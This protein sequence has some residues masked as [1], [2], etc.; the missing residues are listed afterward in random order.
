MGSWRSAKQG[1][2]TIGS[3]P[4]CQPDRQG[5][6]LLNIAIVQKN[7]DPEPIASTAFAVVHPFTNVSS[8]YIYRYLRSPSFVSYVESVQTGIAYPAINDKQ[9]F[10][11]LFP[12]PPTTEQHR[13]VAKVDELM[14]LCD[15]LEQQ[16]EASLG[17]HQ[18]LVETLLAALTSAASQEQLSSAWQHIAA[19]FETLF[20]TEESI[21][22][23]KQTILQLAVM[24]K[25][26]SQDPNDEPASEL[27]K[28]IAVEKEK[29][30]KE[31]KI[32]KEKPLPRVGDQEEPFRL[33]KGWEW[34][35]LQEVID[36]RDGTHDSPKDA[37]SGSVCLNRFS[38]KISESLTDRKSTRLNSSHPQ[39]S[40]MP[41]SA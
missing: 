35:R 20:T 13:I 41:S 36:V 24:G 32:K 12:L 2:T 7:F 10:S 19:H 28:K 27:L 23:L 1:Q 4:V 33:P 16:T 5:P 18:A 30:L 3:V 22:Q 40:R 9:F 25:L 31:G 38:R 8:S 37:R 17:A 21:D 34:C 11:G 6:Y 39:Q 29:L 15:Q 26:V 14:A